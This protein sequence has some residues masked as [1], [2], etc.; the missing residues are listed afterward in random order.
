MNGDRRAI[1]ALLFTMAVWGVSPV[2][3]RSLSVELGPA[4]ALVIRYAA[5]APIFAAVLGIYGGWQ[6][7]RADWPRLMLA[8]LIGML[9]YNIGS[10][11]GFEFAPASI[12]GLIIG[13]QPLLIVV[14]AALIGREPLT[15]ATIIGVIVGFGGT[16]VLFWN[17]LSISGDNA[18]LLRGGLLIFISG[19]AWAFYVVIAKPLILKYGSLP[20]SGLSIIIATIPMLFLASYQTIATAEG[21]TSPQWSAMGFMVII[22]TFIASIAWNYGAGRLSAATAGAFL[23]LVPI[24]AVGAGAIFL[25]EPISTSILLGGALILAGVAIAQSG[26]RWRLARL[27]KR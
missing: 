18:S 14:F 16:A 27:P 21:M 7:A 13:T 5:V 2:F 9:G 26:E 25:D 8:S 1:L 10:V 23:Y 6:I 22:S 11:F 17:D 20:V 12:G 3:T 24:L 19:S 15:P 4:D